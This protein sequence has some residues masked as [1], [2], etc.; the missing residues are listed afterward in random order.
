[1]YGGIEDCGPNATKIVPNGDVYSMRLSLKECR[2][3]KEKS[4]S[5]GEDCPPARA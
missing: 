4:H 1:M 3:E 5:I 2:W